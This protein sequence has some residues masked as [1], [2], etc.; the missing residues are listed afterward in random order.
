MRRSCL[1]KYMYKLL[2]LVLRSS[3]KKMKLV[4]YV[5]VICAFAHVDISS[6][7]RVNGGG[8]GE[9]CGGK[10]DIKCAPELEC[11]LTIYG[12]VIYEDSPPSGI[13]VRPGC[14]RPCNEDGD[15]KMRGKW[16]CNAK[17]DGCHETCIRGAY[18]LK[19]LVPT[20]Y[21]KNNIINI[22]IIIIIPLHN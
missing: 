11:R 17:K 7:K 20:T 19:L 18:H 15:C 4:A 10:Q 22:N 12:D 8:N 16:K 13:C 5:M 3:G 6:S 2:L 14:E 21:N 1:L 9:Q